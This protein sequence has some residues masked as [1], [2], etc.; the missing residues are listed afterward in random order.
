MAVGIYKGK[1]VVTEKSNGTTF[2]FSFPDSISQFKKLAKHKTSQVKPELNQ[3]QMYI[4]KH[5][6]VVCSSSMLTLA[7]CSL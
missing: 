5:N 6:I 2:K 3:K 7:L 4:H 1:S